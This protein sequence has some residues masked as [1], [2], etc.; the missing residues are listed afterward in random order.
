MNRLGDHH[1]GRY[2]RTDKDVSNFRPQAT[3]PIDD[4][5]ANEQAKESSPFYSV[6][7]QNTKPEPSPFRVSLFGLG[8]RHPVG[9]KVKVAQYE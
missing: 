1:V 7:W 5:G 9:P 6:F 4:S 8:T 3:R 2:S